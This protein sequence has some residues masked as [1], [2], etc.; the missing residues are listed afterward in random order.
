M[1]FWTFQAC[2]MALTLLTIHVV[3]VCLRQKSKRSNPSLRLPPGP[4]KL[5]IVGNAL[6]F[7]GPFGRNP[8]RML[9]RL[10]ATYGPVM[11]FRAGTAGTFVVVSSPD[12]A[13]EALVANDAALAARLVPDT[14]RAMAHSSASLLFLPSSDAMW[15]QHR[16]T[17]GA[18]F[19]SGQGL[20]LTRHIRERHAR[21][22][23]EHF[24]ACSG[25]PVIIG[26]AVLGT[27]LNVVS[28]IVF[29]EDVVDMR[30]QAGKQLF[31]DLMVSVIKEWTRPNV[32]D[33]FPFL[34]PLDITGSRR[35]ISRDLAKLYKFFDEEFI[36]P[37]LRSGEKRGDLFDVVLERLAKSELTRSEITKFF[38]DIF[39]TASNT[40]RIT[41]EWAM[42]LLLKYPDKMKKL[43]CE[44]AANLLS[45]DFVEESDLANHPYLLCRG[46]GDV[47]DA[48]SCAS[49]T[50]D[51][52]VG[53]YVLVNLLSI[54]RDPRVWPDPE[55]FKP[56]R[57]LG[58]DQAFYF[59]GTNF[60]FRPFGAGRRV[61]PGMDFAARLEPLVLA[62][63]LHKI[64]WTLPARMAPDDIDL[65]RDR[66]SMMLELDRPLRAVP[67]STV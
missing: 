60:A 30:A 49:D 27:V 63:I 52:P 67:V 7:I 14:A 44:L 3:C 6:H 1:G 10:A 64:D 24:R 61:C 41:V 33:G 42:A 47:A 66:Y 39:L 28:N 17:I 11:S 37:R 13:R 54:G 36:E 2:S 4:I 57:F 46:E 19:S 8:H 20:E 40:S 15:K 56:E 18:R 45:K 9:A 26:E 43:R 55:E 34:A 62:S 22:L 51:V 25:R 65:Q 5:P 58:A 12:A 31:R 50:P 29:S 35:R 23:A 16:A 38:T 48:A 53:T 32:S 21:R 59:R